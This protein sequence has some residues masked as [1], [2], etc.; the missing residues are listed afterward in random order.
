MKY[1]NLNS[2]KLPTLDLSKNLTLEE[3]NLSNNLLRDVEIRHIKSIKKLIIRDNNLEKMN[4]SYMND[5]EY[6]DLENNQLT[7]A[8]IGNNDKLSYVNLK[9]NKLLSMGSFVTNP[10]LTTL[11]LQNNDLLRLYMRNS[12]TKIYKIDVTNNPRLKCI[13]VNDDF[14]EWQ[15]SGWKTDD[16]V[17]FSQNCN[18][19][20]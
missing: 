11:Y 1:L 19:S 14:E 12:A 13:E 9:N 17:T 16:H 10:S 4:L 15:Y 7:L 6:L 18:Y 8:N 20:N 2:N 3:V 5:L